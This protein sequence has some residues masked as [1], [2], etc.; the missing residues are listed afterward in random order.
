MLGRAKRGLRRL[1]E[2]GRLYAAIEELR[3]L[4][5]RRSPAGLSS[6]SLR[7]SSLR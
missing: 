1:I 5:S 2:A 7:R 4:S 6:V 3:R